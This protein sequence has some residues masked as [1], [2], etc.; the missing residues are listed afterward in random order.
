MNRTYKYHIDR[1]TYYWSLFH[2]L[3]FS[4]MG[5][6]L[7]FL[8]EGGYL[9]AWYI[10][11]IVAVVLLMGL[12]IPRRIV[13]D[14]EK[15]TIKCLLDMTQ[16]NIDQIASVRRVL[17]REVRWV[18]PIF[19]ACGFFGYY[20]HYFDLRHFRRVVIYA[21]EWRNMVEII[22]IYEDHYYISCR[23]SDELVE[24]LNLK[25]TPNKSDEDSGDWDD[26][27]IV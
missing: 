17:P 24:K 16:L 22:D 27:G 25:I 5:V 18:F 12:S 14:D 10:T 21:S 26:D 15:L 9:S 13:V 20:G 7:Y 1:R 23:Q 2:L 3:I 11:F 6:A 8:Y 4:M 19:G